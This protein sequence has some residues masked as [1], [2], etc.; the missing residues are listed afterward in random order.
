MRLDKPVDVEDE[1]AHTAHVES[2][3]H[4]N[5][6]QYYRINYWLVA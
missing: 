3:R 6:Q 1:L 5:P 2:A 4:G